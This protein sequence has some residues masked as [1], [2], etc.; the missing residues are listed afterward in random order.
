MFFF[1]GGGLAAGDAW[2]CGLRSGD[3]LTRTHVVVIIV[4]QHRLAVLGSLARKALTGPEALDP[5]TSAWGCGGR[6][7]AA[8]A[9]R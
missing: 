9:P 6:R 7:K 8:R 5:W 2:E 1:H 4:T 3:F